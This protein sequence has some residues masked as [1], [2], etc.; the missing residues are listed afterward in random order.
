MARDFVHA[1]EDDDGNESDAGATPTASRLPT[2][3]RD[4]IV[5]ATNA[6]GVSVRAMCR[7]SPELMRVAADLHASH[8]YPFRVLGDAFRWCIDRGLKDLCGGAGIRS[9]WAQAEIIKQMNLDEAYNAQF[10]DAFRGMKPIVERYLDRGEVG[11]CRKYLWGIW[12]AIKQMP[13]DDWKTQYE[14][15]FLRRYG[16]ILDGGT[17]VGPAVRFALANGT[18]TSTSS[19]PAAAGDPV[20]NGHGSAINRFTTDDDE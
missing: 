3:E 17:T 13:P 10:E 19:V 1:T 2:R 7:V 15:E 16:Q 8:K 6:K 14:S 18:P 5:P 9:V 4:Y 20:A 12:E 11:R